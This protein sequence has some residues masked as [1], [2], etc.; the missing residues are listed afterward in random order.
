MQALVFALLLMLPPL[1]SDN[2]FAYGA[3]G[4]LVGTVVSAGVQAWRG[5]SQSKVEA[6]TVEKLKQETGMLLDDRWKNIAERLDREKDEL[7]AQLAG[8]RAELVA[9]HVEIHQL[10]EQLEAHGWT[11]P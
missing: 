1:A 10:R 8:L 11:G 7:Q 3:A 4:A 9:C 6:A 5:R 2:G